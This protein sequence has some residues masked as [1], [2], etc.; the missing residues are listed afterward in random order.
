ME[1]LLKYFPALSNRQKDQMALLGP[2]YNRWNSH[3]NLISRQDI[4]SLYMKHVLHS[5]SIGRVVSFRPGT[6]ILDAGTGGGFPGIPLAILFPGTAF[7]LADSTGKKIR[8]VE[9]IAGELELQNVTT[10]QVRLEE[11]RG[12]FDF[13][14]G[15]AVATLPEFY[16]W[17]GKNVSSTP[18]NSLPNGILYLKGGDL[19]Q[20][21]RPFGKRA[22]LFELREI[23]DEPAFDT[24]KLVHIAV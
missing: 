14:T 15:R 20:E 4:G 2:L 24:K 19:S 9:S 7:H 10:E 13:V 18:R 21:L 17:T 23:F 12:K 3:I 6:T 5:L 11:I 8:T 1:T 16:R 22:T